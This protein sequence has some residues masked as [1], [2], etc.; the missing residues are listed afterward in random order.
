MSPADVQVADVVLVV[1]RSRGHRD[2]ADL[3]RFEH[4]VRVER[5]RP[6][7]VDLDVEQPRRP[8]PPRTCT[9]RPSAGR[10]ADVA[11]TVLQR[12]IVDLDDQPVRLVR[13]LATARLAPGDAVLDQRIEIVE[14][15]A[16]RLHQEAEPLEVVERRPLARGCLSAAPSSTTIWYTHRRMGRPAVMRARAGAATPPQS[17]AGWRR[18]ARPSRPALNRWKSAMAVYASRARPAVRAARRPRPRPPGCAGARPGPC[19]GWR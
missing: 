11:Q 15:P 8:L 3:H 5:A 6:P 19:A 16:P 14:Q 2:A 18:C 7:N 9:R 12:K 4:C 17:C 13:Q 1:Q 10:L